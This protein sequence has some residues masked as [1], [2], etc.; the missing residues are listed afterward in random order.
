MNCGG[1]KLWVTKRFRVYDDGQEIAF[2]QASPGKGFC[3]YLAN[4]TSPDFGCLKFE[5]GQDHVEII[6]ISGLAW[7]HFKM[8][9]CPDCAVDAAGCYRCAGTKLVRYYDDGYVGEERTR[10]HPIEAERLKAADMEE[11]RRKAQAIIDGIPLPEVVDGTKLAPVEKDIAG[12]AG[13][14]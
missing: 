6:H 1:C 9:P 2:F 14:L 7:Q 3:E 11:R 12:I 10:L 5:A 8:G 4:E 13:P